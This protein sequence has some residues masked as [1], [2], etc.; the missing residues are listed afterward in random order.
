MFHHQFIRILP[1]LKIKM[2]TITNIHNYFP[3][4]QTIISTIL[5]ILFPENSLKP[6]KCAPNDISKFSKMKMFFHLFRPLDTKTLFSILEKLLHPLVQLKWIIFEILQ[7]IT[8][9]VF[10]LNYPPQMLQL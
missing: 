8:V 4:Q 10:L 3:L 5:I 7:Q 9:R 2:V 6:E 1:L